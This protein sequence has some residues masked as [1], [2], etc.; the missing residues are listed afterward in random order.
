MRKPSLLLLLVLVFAPFSITAFN[1]YAAEKTTVG[2]AC[3]GDAAAAD[4]DAIFQCVS[5]VWKRAAIWLGSS[6]D[7]CD[8][9]K[10]GIIQWTGTS[11]QGCD[12]SAWQ[13]LVSSGP[14]PWPIAG[15]DNGGQVIYVAACDGGMTY[16]TASGCTGTRATYVWGPDGSTG[17]T[18]LITGKANSAVLGALGSSYAAAYYC[19]NLTAHGYSDWYLPAPDEMVRIGSSSALIGTATGIYWSSSERDS[20]GSTQAWR[21]V[22]P[23]GAMAVIGKDY[24]YYVR[25]IRRD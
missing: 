11:F 4:W 17:T 3:S 20:P 22:I 18:S 10:A 23:S 6:S 12:G 9:T 7:T 2:G 24:S 16:S 19:E 15:V 21:V 13:S 14:P 5:S 8:S 25:C 1:V